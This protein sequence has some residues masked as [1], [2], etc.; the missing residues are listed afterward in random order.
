[1]N[2]SGEVTQSVSGTELAAISVPGWNNGTDTVT[3]GS[4]L[5]SVPNV[6]PPKSFTRGGHP[7]RPGLDPD[8]LES[9]G[10]GGTF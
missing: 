1:M 7:L 3:S 2:T 6:H 9:G 8:P 5:P 4:D 10:L